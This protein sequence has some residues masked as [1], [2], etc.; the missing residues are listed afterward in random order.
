MFQK[1]NTFRRLK[2]V[3]ILSSFFF[4][5]WA[6]LAFNGRNALVISS[7]HSVF[8]E[9]LACRWPVYVNF[10]TVFG[11]NVCNKLKRILSKYLHSISY[12]YILI[13]QAIWTLMVWYFDYNCR[14][15]FMYRELLFRNLAIADLARKRIKDDLFSWGKKWN[16]VNICCI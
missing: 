8:T 14:M 16:A 10:L 9:R 6:R 15:V 2:G 11:L 7:K 1:L 12:A 4:C 3:I 5:W 13:S